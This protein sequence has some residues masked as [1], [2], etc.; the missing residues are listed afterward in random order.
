MRPVPRITDLARN[1]DLFRVHPASM[2]VSMQGKGYFPQLTTTQT[3]SSND[4]YT[5]AIRMLLVVSAAYC[6][7]QGRWIYRA[8]PGNRVL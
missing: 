2:P 6:R 7:H 1:A 4:I 3:A 5:Q 8:W